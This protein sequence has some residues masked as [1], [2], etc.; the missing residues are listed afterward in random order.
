[1]AETPDEVVIRTVETKT[2]LATT[3]HVRRAALDANEYHRLT[4][5]HHELAELTGVPPFHVKLGEATS[6]ATT[7]S[8]LRTAILYPGPNDACA[9]GIEALQAMPDS[10]E[11]LLNR[12]A[13]IFRTALAG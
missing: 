8:D 4:A 6:D 1:M 9:E 13:A 3:H 10:E 7:F 12:A 2:G 5:V 11:A